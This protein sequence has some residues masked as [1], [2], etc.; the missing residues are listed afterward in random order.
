[1]SSDGDEKGRF[2]ACGLRSFELGIRASADI[3]KT[4][5]VNISGI[6]VRGSYIL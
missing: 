1:V 6:N 5:I 3:A 2:N 4:L